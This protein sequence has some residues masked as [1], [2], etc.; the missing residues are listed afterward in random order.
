MVVQHHGAVAFMDALQNFLTNLPSRGPQAFQLTLHDH[1]DC[2]SNVH[3]PLQP[4]E[5]LSESE[6]ETA[7]IHSHPEHANGPCKPPMPAQ[8]DTIL[9][10]V[11]EGHGMARGDFKA[12]QLL[13]STEIYSQY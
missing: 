9:V 2:F 1:F 11:D 8:Y 10:Q 5:H 6:S 4:L 7:R 13:A 12:S 3:I